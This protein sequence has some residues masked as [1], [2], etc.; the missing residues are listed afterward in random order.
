MQLY[1]VHCG[2]YDLELSDGIYESHVNYFVAAE[3]FEHARERAKSLPEFRAKKMHVDGVQRIEAVHGHRVVLER[4]V[5][6]SEEAMAI[7]SHR[8][9]DLAPKKPHEA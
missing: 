9:R 1:L 7:V 5:K 6:L 2:F 4:D 3:S 8:H